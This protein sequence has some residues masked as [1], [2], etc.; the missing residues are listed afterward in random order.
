MKK[1][2]FKYFWLFLALSISF[3]A[4]LKDEGYEDGLYGSIK[5]TT[6]KEYMSIPVAPR[7][8][9]TLGLESK[10]GVQ[11]IELFSVSYDYVD[12]A[13]TDISATIA[14]NNSLVTDPAVI[15]LPASTYSLPSNT[16]TVKAGQ[17]VSD[18]FVL[19][20]N[21]STLDPTKKY[22]IGFTMESVSKAG[23]QIPSNTK[24]VVYVFSLKNTWDG[25]YSVLSGYVQR[26]TAPGTPT[27]GDALNG[28]LEGNP[29]VTLTTVGPNTVEV[30]NLRWA[31]PGTSGVAGIDNLQ[32]TID[33]ATNQVTTKAL[34]NATLSNW[35]GKENRYD[36]ATKTF[37]LGFIWNPSANVRTYEIVMKYKG[38]RP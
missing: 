18:K 25:V 14:V 28:T 7:N 20:I 10:A 24:N 3:T 31:K 34:G 23:V 5:N 33:P 21:T 9:N 15:V 2:S 27:V 36:P 6:G 13:P 26:Y 4:C 22:G 29:D 35:A 8:P 1:L 37:Y 30:S 38:P 11:N 12:P 16:I 17:R 19:N 32:L